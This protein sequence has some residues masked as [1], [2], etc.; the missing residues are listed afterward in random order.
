MGLMQL[1]VLFTR[2]LS[3]NIDNTNSIQS[4]VLDQ[5]VNVNNFNNLTTLELPSGSKL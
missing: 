2:L 3:E 4:I 5:T 1:M